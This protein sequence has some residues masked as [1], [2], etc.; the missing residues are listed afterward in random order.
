MPVEE[1]TPRIH[2][3]RGIRKLMY[4][5]NH[6]SA[7][8]ILAGFNIASALFVRIKGQH[9][10]SFF[11]V[12]QK[13]ALVQMQCPR[14]TQF[15]NLPPD[16][17]PPRDA[18]ISRPAVLVTGFSSRRS[19]GRACTGRAIFVRRPRMPAPPRNGYHR[20]KMLQT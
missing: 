18:A 14:Y 12:Q 16:D 20:R 11:V 1:P 10:R 19:T 9:F 2:P 4:W 15:L 8:T 17:Q 5:A 3:L 13:Q 7:R 6:R